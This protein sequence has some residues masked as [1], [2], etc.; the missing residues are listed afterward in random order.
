MTKEERRLRALRD[1]LPG[2]VL[3]GTD[4]SLYPLRDRIGEGSQGWVFRATWNGS[5][6]VVVKV[7]RPEAA[8]RDT[9]ARFQREAQVL[10]MLSQQPRP[11]P[12]VVRFFDHAYASIAVPDTGDTWNLPFTVL[13][14]VDGPTLETVLSQS[15]P[16]GL[17]IDRARRILRHTS[18]ALRDVHGQ[19]VVHRDLKPSNILIAASGE[20]EIAKVT[21]FGLAKLIDGTGH[22][23]TF[24]GAT[25]GY[26]PPEQFEHGNKRV[27]RHTDVFSL[28]TIFYELVTG[29][30]AFPFHES[31]NPA[32]VVRRILENA[33]PSFARVQE[34]LPPEL[35]QRP[36]VV[37]ALD[38]EL[39]RA[40]S[41]EPGERHPTVNEL[42]DAMERA[43]G[44]LGGATSLPRAG[45]PGIVGRSSAPASIRDAE[46][47]TAAP[48]ILADPSTVTAAPLVRLSSTDLTLEANRITWSVVT[49]SVGAGVFRA[50]GVSLDGSWAIGAGPG[51]VG[52]WGRGG[53]TAFDA[54]RAIDPHLIRVV[55]ISADDDVMLAG[56]GPLVVAVTPTG[57]ALTTR[58]EGNPVFCSGFLDSNGGMTLAGGVFVDGKVCGV[59]AQTSPRPGGTLAPRVY[60][61]PESGPL[62]G[63]V[64]FETD[65]LACGDAGS[66][67][68]L[69]P[70]GAKHVSACDATLNAVI[71]VGDGTAAAVGV[72]GHALRVWPSLETQL[73]SI[74]TTRA[75]QALARSPDGVIW[76]AGAACRVLFRDQG[77]WTRVGAVGG[78]DSVT[79]VALRATDTHVLAFCDDGTVLE[80]ARG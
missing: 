3:P 54:G 58:F 53:W 11:N 32:F 12:H 35:Q 77:S 49:T 14:Y 26:A 46:I 70:T 42:Y 45:H 51:G 38:V 50:V 22:K 20:R 78:A 1:V 10:R 33:R 69:R 13:E 57:S 23:T 40:L 18:L 5:V 19:N 68:L 30:T 47:M 75:L 79:I 52:R 9:L 64:R 29:A 8:T 48:T 28:A 6:D 63:V 61:I 80:G 74:Q 2:Q 66:L 34:R 72:G 15:S 67:V 21:D 65:V 36:D 71:A 4:G 7:L 24:A 17:G 73:E 43:V 59:I 27:G 39:A 76:T 55:S 60:R 31:D 62:R 16:A 25:V 37:A 56:D 44:L 41:P